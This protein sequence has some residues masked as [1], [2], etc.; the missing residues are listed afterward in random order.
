[1]TMTEITEAP[2]P[3]P[4]PGG[5]HCPVA[6]C[7]RVFERKNQLSGHMISHR[8]DIYCPECSKPYKSPGALGNHRKHE[9]SVA[10]VNGHKEPS[11]AAKRVDAL[12]E[13]D[14]GD[15]LTSLVDALRPNGNI[16][17][18]VE[19]L[20]SVAEWYVATEELIEILRK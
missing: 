11:K 2:T 10:S 6:G 7:D 20:R 14:A 15:V 4:E 3:T 17:L 5:V 19:A 16:T 18:S 13:V 12:E 1:M 8:P 9:H